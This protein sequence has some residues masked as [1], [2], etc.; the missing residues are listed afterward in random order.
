MPRKVLARIGVLAALLLPAGAACAACA[1]KDASPVEAVRQMYAGAM[2]GDRARTLAAFDPDGFLFDGG[3]RFTPEAIADL[4]LK[5]E[6]AGITPSWAVEGVESHTVCDLA[7]AA[8]TTRGTF[9]T[10]AGAE[11]RIWL[12]SG[13]FVWREGTWKIR[14]FHSTPGAPSP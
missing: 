8:W 14:F 4:I 6:A 5:S 3:K 13:V 12:E 9:T 10:K 7:W 1:P 2:A 11:P